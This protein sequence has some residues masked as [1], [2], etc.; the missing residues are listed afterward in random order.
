MNSGKGRPK[1]MKKSDVRVWHGVL[2]SEDDVDLH[3]HCENT[4]V[5]IDFYDVAAAKGI[6]TVCRRSILYISRS[7]PQEWLQQQPT[8]RTEVADRR[9]VA[10]SRR[11]EAGHTNTGLSW[12]RFCVRKLNETT[13]PGDKPTR[14]VPQVQ[15]GWAEA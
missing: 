3:F 11:K 6:T 10:G 9:N 7:I 2:N 4:S 5:L 15:I 12:S 1:I 8:R 14:L 13:C